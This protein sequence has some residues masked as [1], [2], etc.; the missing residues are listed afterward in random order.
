MALSFRNTIQDI[1][2]SYGEEPELLTPTP[3]TPQDRP[4]GCYVYAHVTEDGKCFY[5]SKGSG[6]RAWSDARH[7]TWYRYV[8]NHLNGKYRVVILRDNLSP[9]RGEDVE[10]E[11]IAQEGATLVNWI[12]AARPLDLEKLD[13][14]HKLRNANRE[15]IAAGR[16]LEKTDL[17]KALECFRNAIAA[18]AYETIEYEGGIVGQLLREDREECGR[19]GEW[20]AIDRLTLCL[21]KLGRGE[22]AMAAANDYYSRYALDKNMACFEGIMKRVWKAAR[23]S[24]K[25]A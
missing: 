3:D 19:Q 2:V 12:N 24:T 7:P 6:R 4:R 17:E 1:V 10:A 25:Q 21:S 14:F 15:L 18:I 22:E 13:Q 20:E 16:R 5:I 23:K 8:D 11:W 9:E